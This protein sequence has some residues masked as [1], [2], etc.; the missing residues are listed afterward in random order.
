MGMIDVDKVTE[1]LLKEMFVRMGVEYSEDFVN[2]DGWY[3]KHSWSLEA[4]SEY[5]KWAVEW[6]RKNLKWTKYRSG[7]EMDWFLVCFGWRHK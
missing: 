3:L 6:L 2:Q 4:E 5:K 1:S 7:R